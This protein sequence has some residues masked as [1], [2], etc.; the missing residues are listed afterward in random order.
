[1]NII[2][3]IKTRKSVRRYADTPVP[4]SILEQIQQA[5]DSAE[6]PFGGE[7]TIRIKSFNH[8]GAFKSGTYGVIRGASEFLLMAIGDTDQ[9]ALS[10]GYKMEQV[11][12]RATELGMGTCWIG[13]TFNSGSFNR[14]EKWPDGEELKI[15]SPI[16]YPAIKQTALDKLSRLAFKSDHRKPLDQLFYN[17]G[18]NRGLIVGDPFE[19]ALNMMRLAPSSTNSQPWRAITNGKD[20]VHFYVEKRGFLH[21]VDCGIGLYHFYLADTFYGGRGHFEKL[22]KHP[23]GKSAWTYLTSYIRTG[24]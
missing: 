24:N 1:M 10:A 3:T 13:G 22:Q 21:L 17:G 4:E 16:G 6:S 9:S 11:V 12:L 18:L 19:P 20:L 8:G 5:I 14:D 2:E 7:T 15:I 23:A